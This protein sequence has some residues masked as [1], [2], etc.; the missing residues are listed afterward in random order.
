QSFEV[1]TILNFFKIKSDRISAE[2]GIQAPGFIREKIKN[3]YPIKEPPNLSVKQASE[4][5]REVNASNLKS[6]I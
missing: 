5:I 6:K 3:L 2:C 4:F 1:L